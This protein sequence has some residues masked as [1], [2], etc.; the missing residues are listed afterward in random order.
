MR[1]AFDLFERPAEGFRFFLPGREGGIARRELCNKAEVY[2]LVT[3]IS[4]LIGIPAAPPFPLAALVDRV[5]ALG[6]FAALWGLEGLGLEYANAAWKDEPPHHPLNGE[7]AAALQARSLPMLHAGMGIAFGQRLI[8]PLPGDATAAEIREV[9]REVTS[10]CRESSQPGYLGAA[11]ESIGLV[12]RTLQ[13]RIVH[14]LDEALWEVDR[15]AVSYFWH[16][17]GRAIYFLPVNFLPCG[18]SLWRAF[19]MAAEE[20]P[21]ELARVNVLAGLAWAFTLVNQRHPEVMEDL[22]RHHGEY[23]A[24]DTAFSEGV[25]ASILLRHVTTPDAPFLSSFCQHRPAR[26]TPVGRSSGTI[27]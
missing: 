19:E 12:T 26:P 10:L 4:E 8:A 17:V 5:F 11:L 13:P 25:A 23:L 14:R 3:G 2:L 20:A 21:H 24:A 6:P 7:S 27:W 16:G 9:A 18:N 22:L 15:E 1:A